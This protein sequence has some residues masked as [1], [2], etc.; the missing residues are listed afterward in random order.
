MYDIIEDISNK[1]KYEE[2]L[3]K[4]LTKIGEAS[5]VLD[6]LMSSIPSREDI[7]KLEEESKKEKRKRSGKKEEKE[8]E[9]R[10]YVKDEL[11][12]I[13]EELRALQEELSKLAGK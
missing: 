7:E 13:E 11:S 9:R 6:N 12:K 2:K 10:D 5:E 1:E 4:I 8:Q 3:N